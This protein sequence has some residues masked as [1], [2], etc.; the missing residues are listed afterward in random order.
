MNFRNKA[1]CAA[2]NHRIVRSGT[3]RGGRIF[4]QGIACFDAH[5]RKVPHIDRQHFQSL[6]FRNLLGH[7]R[8]ANM[9]FLGLLQPTAQIKPPAL[10]FD[11]DGGV[12]EKLHSA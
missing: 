5:G 4:Q 8:V 3:G 2:V 10:G 7:G 11:Q 6:Q 9:N 12:N 1:E